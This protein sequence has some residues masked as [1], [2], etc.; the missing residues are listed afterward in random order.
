MKLELCKTR[1]VLSSYSARGMNKLFSR[2][3]AKWCGYSLIA[4]FLIGYCGFSGVQVAP[5]E[6]NAAK[7]AAEPGPAEQQ[8]SPLAGPPAM[9]E[10]FRQALFGM[11]EEQVR[12]AV[13]KDFPAA[14]AKIS[15]AIHP[16]EKTTVLSLTVA[17]LLPNTGNARISYIFGYRSKKLIQINIVWTSE[18]SAASDATLVGTANSLRDYF[19]S[20]NYKPDSTVANRQLAENTILVF[21]ANDLQGRTVLLMLSG[22]A[23]AARG[24]EKKGS[25]PP[26]L[27]LELSYILDTAH[28]DVFRIAKGQF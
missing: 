11:S 10:G 8:P 25:R 15:S 21:R 18:G 23:A 22:V 5:A 3:A 12:Q 27:T 7:G 28:P 17:D 24:E 20:Q 6:D 2:R 16:S 9:I 19:A 26:P 13:R 14:T 4:V 1:L